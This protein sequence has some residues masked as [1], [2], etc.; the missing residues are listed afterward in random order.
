MGQG[1]NEPMKLITK[2]FCSASTWYLDWLEDAG[3]TY[4]SVM[5][6]DDNP[7]LVMD[8]VKSS[9]LDFSEREVRDLTPFLLECN[10]TVTVDSVK[11]L[12]KITKA[13]PKT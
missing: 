5:N 6:L 4:I 8:V 1:D 11:V 12:S 10:Y 13:K 2:N 3:F 9:K 7:E